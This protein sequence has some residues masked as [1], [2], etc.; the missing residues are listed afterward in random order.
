MGEDISGKVEWIEGIW[1]DGMSDRSGMCR[2]RFRL[3]SKV[4]EECSCVSS[5][6]VGLEDGEDE[7]LMSRS[8]DDRSV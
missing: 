5:G 1:R 3:S 2:F 7:V 6:G 8:A 4:S